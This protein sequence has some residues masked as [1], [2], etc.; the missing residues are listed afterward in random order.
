MVTPNY[1]TTGPF[2]KAFSST[3]LRST[4]PV[5]IRREYDSSWV[6]YYGEADSGF[7]INLLTVQV[8]AHSSFNLELGVLDLVIWLVKCPLVSLN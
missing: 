4:N 5:Q 1:K 2:E 6:T 7:S 3:A 8:T